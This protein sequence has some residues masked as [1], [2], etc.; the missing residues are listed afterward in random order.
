MPRGPLF[1]A[2]LFLICLSWIAG[3]GAPISKAQSDHSVTGQPSNQEERP[4]LAARLKSLHWSFQSNDEQAL[5]QEELNAVRKRT[6]SP[7]QLRQRSKSNSQR[8]R[9]SNERKSTQAR[10]S[11]SKKSPHQ[12]KQTRTKQT[13]SKQTQSKQTKPK[14]SKPLL[15][16]FHAKKLIP[17]GF[18]S[19]GNK[20]TKETKKTK[21]TSQQHSSTAGRRTKENHNPKTRS[22]SQRVNQQ[23]SRQ[24]LNSLSAQPLQK[25]SATKLPLA[26]RQSPQLRSHQGELESALSDLLADPQEHTNQHLTITP[27][28]ADDSRPLPGFLEEQLANEISPRAEVSQ[29]TQIASRGSRAPN[30]SAPRAQK[31]LAPPTSATPA[32]NRLEQIDSGSSNGLD[33]REALLNK[34]SQS[35]NPNARFTPPVANS[36]QDPQEQLAEL[37]LTTTLKG[38]QKKN[39]A[40]ESKTLAQSPNDHS[41]ESLQTENSLRLDQEIAQSDN[42]PSAPPTMGGVSSEGNQ[43]RETLNEQKKVAT[44]DQPENQSRVLLTTQ[45]PVIVSRV[46]GPQKILVGRK[47]EYHIILNNRGDVAADALIAKINIPAW[48]EIIKTTANSGTTIQAKTSKDK[49]TVLTSNNEQQVLEWQLG[50]LEPKGSQ[51]LQLQL[52]PRSGRPMHLGVNWTHAPV[53][54][55]ATVEVQ[56]PKLRITLS[57]PTDVLYGKPQ[58][59]RLVLHNPGTGV[60]EEVSINLLPPGGAVGNETNHTIGSLS[61]GSTKVVELELTAR[62]AGDLEVKATAVAAG[63]LRTETVK[64]VYCRKA[65]L[66]LDWR[67]PKSKYA[68]TESTYYFRVRNPGSALTDPLVVKVQLPDGTKYVSASE[69]ETYDAETKSVTWQLAGLSPD[70]EQFMQLRC[71]LN[72]P[73]QNAIQLTAETVAG[74]L[75]DTKLIQTKVVAMAD[76]KL[77]VSDPKGPFP[78]NKSG[79]YE[80]RIVNRGTDQAKNIQIVALFS[81]GIDPT[82]VNGKPTGDGSHTGEDNPT[83]DGN[84]ATIRDGRVSFKPIQS[85]A[86]GATLVLQIHAEASTPGTHIFRAEVVCQELDIKLAAEETTRFFEDSWAE[87]NTPYVAEGKKVEGS[88]RR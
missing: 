17:S 20:Q 76:L 43:V 79:I 1:S 25:P 63:D 44:Q 82:T 71:E 69:G 55:K 3:N 72:K 8:S 24:G 46:E 67:G 80:I 40:K 88:T 64:K 42:A 27:P 87:G 21:K 19:F 49:T 48:A 30:Q 11:S 59:Y 37:P 86:A 7:S 56:E 61:P 50:R 84:L 4:S 81:K 36:Q 33:L 16:G 60:A 28:K 45:Q 15:S 54:S 2:T 77:T 22:H 29:T 41:A 58:R 23:Q 32:K 74:D 85:I 75:S 6:A 70:E 26:T 10:S 38:K 83:I 13:Q 66:T 51:Q 52:I 18:F 9:S 68:G 5:T 14:K 34:V 65:E 39:G 31:E 12:S 73:G 62:Q 47:S 57:G 35:P 53:D 78:I